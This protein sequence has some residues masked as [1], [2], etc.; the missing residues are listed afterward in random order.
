MVVLSSKNKAVIT[1]L[2]VCIISLIYIALNWVSLI[3]DAYIFFRYAH[4]IIQG[5]GYSFN[6]GHPVEGTTSVTW[7]MLLVGFELCHIP[8]EVS[9]KIL[10][11]L[12]VLGILFLLGNE[13]YKTAV[14]SSV[15][16]LVFALLI[17]DKNFIL[18][19]MMGLET[20]LYALLLLAICSV[21]R[22]YVEQGGQLRARAMGGIGVLL[23]LT[24]P[25]S[26]AILVLLGCGLVFLHQKHKNHSLT[27]IFIWILGITSTTLWRWFAFG[28]VIPNSAR[29]KSVLVFSNIHWS[30]VWPRIVAGSL[31]VENALLPAW[32]LVVLGVVGLVSGR[33]SF[34]VYGAFSALFVGIGVTLMNSGDWMPFSRLLTPYLPITALLAGIG[35]HKLRM[36]PGKRWH[37]KVEWASFFLAVLITLNAFWSLQG[38]NFFVAA[39]WPTGMCYRKLGQVLQPY[40]SKQ[41][42]VAPEALGQLGYTLID[43]PMLD[44]FGLTDSYIARNGVIPI[45][46]YTLGKHH[47]QYT[48][49]QSPDLFLLHSDITNH[50]PLLNQWGYSQQYTTFRI[51]DTQLKCELLVGT[52]NLLAADL[53]PVLEQNFKVQRVATSQIPKN[54]AA[55]WPEG[56]R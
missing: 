22:Q 19:V 11:T 14:P 48:M 6:S 24:R 33:K 2:F 31:Y 53:L 44:F 18:S 28:D 21:S 52:K 49:Q 27:P 55:T 37:K 4:N 16:L 29:A 17:F 30:I 12:C 1:L 47:Y 25:E 3:D 56:A 50:I 20:G 26:V 15:G 41:N 54:L 8:A 13:F 46:T 51:T 36:L 10:G 5:Y 9:V 43:V 39:Q 42:L 40:I 35:V 7:T 45:E 38:R 23:F 34:Q 32:F